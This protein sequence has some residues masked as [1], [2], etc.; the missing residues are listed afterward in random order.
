VLEEPEG[1]CSVEVSVPPDEV[2]AR[3]LRGLGLQPSV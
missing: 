3:I 1:V 2:V